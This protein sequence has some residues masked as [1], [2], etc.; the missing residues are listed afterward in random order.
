MRSQGASPPATAQLPPFP[1]PSHHRSGCRRRGLRK[2]GRAERRRP[3]VPRLQRNGSGLTRR[4][5]ARAHPAQRPLAR[6]TWARTWPA[7]PSARPPE[8][9]C[10]S[11]RRPLGTP[12]RPHATLTSRSWALP[13][14][15]AAP[16]PGGAGRGTVPPRTRPRPRGL[17]GGGAPAGSAPRRRARAR[18]RVTEGRSL[19]LGPR[20]EGGRAPNPGPPPS[21]PPGRRRARSRLSP[22]SGA[23][24]AAG[25]RAELRRVA[26]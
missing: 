25:P 11:P 22:A 2:A 24:G 4:G 1:T 26:V 18:A 10:S 17:H 14:L 23:R 19:L 15:T 21:D 13:A 20:R 12:T 7:R 3:R 5:A 8:H 16:G 9:L 6:H